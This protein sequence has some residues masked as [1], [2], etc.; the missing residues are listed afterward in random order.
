MT[1]DVST[2]AIKVDSGS[3]VENLKDFGSSI[4][5]LC[6]L[7]DSLG[8]KIFQLSAAFLSVN[9]AKSIVNDAAEGQEALGKFEAVLGRFQ[10]RANKVVDELVAKFNFD[11]ASAQSAVSGMVDT[12]AK[13]GMS[14]EDSLDM[15]TALNKRASDLEAFTNAQGGVAAVS[16]RLTSGVLGNSEAVKSLGIVMTEDLVKAQA[17]KEK[18]EGL[19]FANERAA[20]MHARV[21]L[22]LQQSVSAEGQV[23]RETD[24]YSNRVRNL[25][26]R[27]ADL[28]G[29]LGD[30]LIPTFTKIVQ[31]TSKVVEVVNSL[32]PT[33]KTTVVMAGA[34]TGG[35]LT[36]SP[37]ITR[38]FI[39]FKTL[40]ATQQIANTISGQSAKLSE[41]N[42]V[43]TTAETLA[44]E[45]ETNSEKESA[46]VSQTVV[47]AKE[48]EAKARL[49]NAK[50]A[51]FE[52]KALS[53]NSVVNKLD[54]PIPLPE[55]KNLPNSVENN[56]QDKHKSLPN[57]GK[58]SAHKKG[59][60]GISSKLNEVFQTTA[61]AKALESLISPFKTLTNIFANLATKLPLVSSFGGT[62]AKMLG[63]F[64]TGAT[65]VGGVITA[66]EVFK[67][68]PQWLEVAF[69]KLPSV[70]ANLG[71]RSLSAVKNL[72][73]NAVN[74]GKNL[75]VKGTLGFAQTA[76]RLAGFE[77]EASRAY[78]LNKQIEENN[79]RRQEL[80]EQEQRQRKAENSMLQT[81]KNAFK[82]IDLAKLDY[83]SSKETDT[84][85]LAKVQ[86]KRDSYNA[87][88]NDTLNKIDEKRR[89]A[90]SK[91][92]TQEQR[93]AAIE[94]IKTLYESLETLKEQWREAA[95]ECDEFT[96]SIKE[97]KK[98]FQEDQKSYE[99]NK[100]E[101][102]KEFNRTKL[103]TN[104]D[105][106]KNHNE[107][108]SAL[109]AIA[110][111][112]KQEYEESG[113]AQQK[114][115]E[116]NSEIQNV[117]S[118]LTSEFAD[119][120]MMTLQE[121]ASTGDFQ[122]DDALIKWSGALVQLEKAGYTIPEE[123]QV[124]GKGS[125]QQLF[126]QMTEKRK[127]QQS[128]LQTLTT[129]R[130]E[131][132]SIANEGASR[133]SAMV[134]A[135]RAVKDENK[136]YEEE[137]H[138]REEQKAEQAKERQQSYKNFQRQ[139]DDT[140]FERQ[141]AASDQYYGND[142]IGAAQSRYQMISARG[143]QQW[144]QSVYELSAK[145]QQ[146]NDYNK[147]LSD[148]EEKEKAGTLT[149]DEAKKRDE[150]QK[151][152]DNLQN[153]YDSEYQ[154]AVQKRLAT[155]D[156][157]LGLQNSARD[158]FLSQAQDY[159]NEQGSAMQEQMMED[160]QKKEEERAVFNEEARQAVSGQS[161]VA[162]GSSEAFNVASKIYDRGQED[163]PPEKEMSDTTKKIEEYVKLMQ[164]Q[165]MAYY[166]EQANG[167][168]LS[169][170]Y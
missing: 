52:T 87:Q 133:Y 31:S 129:Q 130:D 147:Q 141:L 145:Q 47:S 11:T 48:A 91:N 9:F 2:L 144:N 112:A 135:N 79:K 22:I 38:L 56:S 167:L 75:I 140:Y 97:N 86:F 7:T 123:Q 119:R 122:S 10:G 143:S 154:E 136:Q 36:L 96:E 15:S 54:N 100:K 13:A 28:R 40:L 109:S 121:L 49:S 73:S 60:F 131:Q 67:N 51:E 132:Q 105:N 39:G 90:S 24:N 30:A 26:A 134:D 1:D 113:A 34:L 108:S 62:F 83:T 85:K 103:Q 111:N 78:K 59:I 64:G 166:A 156:E 71:K 160:A 127:E 151:K 57:I 128:N 94:E 149:D 139:I 102:A 6:G 163:V 65:V 42:A 114:A 82:S 170:G 164:E 150:I 29:S 77:T 41:E 115:D 18:T 168:T 142:K 69:D 88:I 55:K 8:E 17:L 148:Y 152:H 32:S 98:A 25:N 58:T 50:A 20:K 107:R 37:Y 84:T 16:E 4:Y 104:L 70:F 116:L 158:E 81:Q 93:D 43:A 68:A 120:A 125:A 162:A 23:A 117:H 61:T 99:K 44:V 118:Q 161:A 89:N 19:T 101:N 146:L 3:A 92:V 137:L 33:M 63:L 124:M 12:F 5:N 138:E 110:Q 21:S 155:E 76:K 27:I 45:Q 165:M 126:T 74:Y 157:L 66:L 72:T 159:V 53:G 14:L 46:F 106:A 169:M 95:E 153:E 35:F 80:I